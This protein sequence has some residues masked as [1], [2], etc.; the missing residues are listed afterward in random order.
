MISVI[1]SD[2][3]TKLFLIYAHHLNFSV[4]FIKQVTFDKGKFSRMISLQT[5]Y[6]HLFANLR[7]QQNIRCLARQ[8]YTQ[9]IQLF[10]SAYKLATKELYRCLVVDLHPAGDGRYRLRTNIFDEHPIIYS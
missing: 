7:D 5:Q 2:A 9:D 10:L 4:I 6:F 1:N 3:I 8:I